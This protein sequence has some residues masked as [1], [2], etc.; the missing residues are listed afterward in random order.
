M[1]TMNSKTPRRTLAGVDIHPIGLGCM[2]LSHAYGKPLSEGEGINLLHRAL[3][4]GVNHFDSAALYGFGRNESLLGKAFKGGLREQI[5]LAS[6]CGMTGVDGK[7]TIDGRPETLKATIDQSLQSLRTDVIDLY[8]LHRLDPDVPIEDSIGT[9]AGMVKAGKIKAIGLSE[10]SVDTLRRAH[11]EHPIAALQTEYSLWSR[12]AEIAAL[13]ACKE[14]GISFVA[15]SP[16]GRGF[17]AN[18]ITDLNTLVDGDIRRGMPRF[19]QPAFDQNLSLL[20]PLKQIASD[21]GIKPSQLVLAW[22]LH[23]ADHIVPIPGTTNL[24]HLE[25]NIAAADVRLSHDI[26]AKVGALINHSTVAGT[27][28]PSATQA[29]IGTEEFI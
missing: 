5:H 11:T 21:L 12:N 24:A 13:D 28:Y 29:E 22:L 6:K 4:L 14:L 27:R 26:L 9:M 2:N 20:A 1:K 15:F 17:L 16:L 23:K 18:G 10:V 3:D 7:R 8:Y 25:L 19:Q